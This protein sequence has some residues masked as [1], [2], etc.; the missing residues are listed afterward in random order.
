MI[1]E[2]SLKTEIVGNVPSAW[3]SRLWRSQKENIQIVAI[4]LLLALFIRAFVAEPRYIPSDSMVPTLQIGD[5]LVVE[6]VSYHFHQPVTGDIIVFSPPQ[7]LQKK[8]FTKDQAFI[9]RAIGSPGQTVAVHNGKVYLDNKPLQEDY[10]AEPPEYEWGPELVP[11]NTYFV[12]GD[13]R[14]DSNDSSKW[15]FLPKRNIIGHA[16][17]RF[18]PLDRG[19]FL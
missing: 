14:N 19:G 17:F 10:I 5:R 4:A 8:G 13:N 3:W 12:M 16:V 7:Q 9:K 15:G 1:K 18:W 2:K 11:E 6:K